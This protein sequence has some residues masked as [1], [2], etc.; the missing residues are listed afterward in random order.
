M[1]AHSM[2]KSYDNNVGKIFISLVHVLE[3]KYL[4]SYL[5]LVEYL[6]KYLAP[7]MYKVPGNKAQVISCTKYFDSPC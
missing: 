2:H 3:S 4:I 7:V 5:H 6:S 1:N